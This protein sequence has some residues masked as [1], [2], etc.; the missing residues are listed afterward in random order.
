[1]EAHGKS[2]IEVAAATSVSP[3]TIK[4]F[5][6]GTTTPSPLVIKALKTL[7]DAAPAAPKQ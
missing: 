4:R 6:E 7:L 3:A 1:M 2:T 5:L